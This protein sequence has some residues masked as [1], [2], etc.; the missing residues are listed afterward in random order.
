MQRMTTRTWIVLIAVTL[1]LNLLFYLPALLSVKTAQPKSVDLPYSAFRTQVD[2]SNVESVTIQGARISGAFKKA[3]DWPPSTPSASSYALFTTQAP[4]LPAQ[5]DTLTAALLAKGVQLTAKTEQPPAWATILGSLANIVPL[6]FLVGFTVLL[7]RKARQGQQTAMGFGQSKAKLYSSERPGI[8]FRDVAGVDEA[9]TELQEVVEFLKDPMRFEKLGAR[10]PRGVLLVGPPGTGKT[11]LARAVAGEA[12]VP[13]FSISATEFVEMFVGVGASR[14][15]DLFDKA[16]KAAPA[17]VFV[18]EI[19]SVGR[20]RGA[21]YG[22]VNDEREQTLNQLLVEMDGFEQNQ[23]VIVLAATNRPD[24]LDPALLRPGRFDREVTV[25]RPDRAGREAILKIHSRKVPLSSDVSLD[26]VAKKT[27]G[28]AGADLANLVNE[29]ALVAAHKGKNVVESVDFSEA[30]DKVLLGVRRAIMLSDDE[31]RI[32]AYHEGGHAIVGRFSEH[33]DPIQKITIVPRGR[34]LGV[35]QMVPD[36]DAHNYGRRYLMDRLA[37][38]MGGRAAEALVLNEVTSGA[39]NDLKEASKLAR[40]MVTEWGMASS[41]PPVAFD[42]DGSAPFL[43]RQLAMGERQYSEEAASAIDR[44]VER[45]ISE[46]YSRATNIIEQ[47]QPEL[48]ALVE[49]LLRD[50][51]VEGSALDQLIGPKAQPALTPVT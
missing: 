32:I 33:A 11:L 26:L 8:T 44:E 25:E 41:L 50:E 5:D 46:A 28:F 13:F 31:R 47:H 42:L 9:K 12:G 14:V 21:G 20:Q 38:A 49:A 39:E 27:P 48:E 17:I 45:F 16:K 15:R 51:V 1:V 30:Q 24:V 43:G 7:F 35:T 4:T 19:D 3:V 40:R 23:G 34:S 18:D 36:H 37:V 29:A 6:L 10:I 22:N 2:A